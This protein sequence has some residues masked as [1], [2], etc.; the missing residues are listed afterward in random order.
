MHGPRV[1]HRQRPCRPQC[2]EWRG[3]IIGPQTRTPSDT[4]NPS[5]TNTQ[6]TPLPDTACEAPASPITLPYRAELIPRVPQLLRRLL[7]SRYTGGCSCS[8]GLNHPASGAPAPLL[9]CCAKGPGG[10]GLRCYPHSPPGLPRVRPPGVGPSQASLALAQG[11]AA[12]PP[13]PAEQRPDTLP[14]MSQAT[15]VAGGHLLAL[16]PSTPAQSWRWRGRFYSGQE[17]PF[18]VLRLPCQGPCSLFPEG[19]PCLA[20]GAWSCTCRHSLAQELR[21][22]PHLTSAGLPAGRASSAAG[23]GWS[24]PPS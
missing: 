5:G 21:A 10:H 3:A 14:A 4:S 22:S 23:P 16:K 9:G 20:G 19:E 1:P 8:W 18:S 17:A 24:P 7:S 2:S 12:A 11:P 13:A 6:R 15:L